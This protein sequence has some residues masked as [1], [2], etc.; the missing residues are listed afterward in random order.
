M[1]TSLKLVQTATTTLS[2]M[3]KDAVDYTPSASKEAVLTS[4]RAVNTTAVAQNVTVKIGAGYIAKELLIPANDV[5]SEQIS[6]ILSEGETVAIQS[7]SDT[8]IQVILTGVERDV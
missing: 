5:I 2:N 3:Q 7:D 4:W 8:A 6:E 1:G